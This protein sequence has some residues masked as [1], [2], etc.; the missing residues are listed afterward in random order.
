MRRLSGR[1]RKVTIV[2]GSVLFIGYACLPYWCG[3]RGIAG[4]DRP[5]WY[6]LPGWKGVYVGGWEDAGREKPREPFLRDSAGT[7]ESQN[8]SR[9]EE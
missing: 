2:V 5:W 4:A 9:T 7:V 6:V 3:Y 1:A 8:T